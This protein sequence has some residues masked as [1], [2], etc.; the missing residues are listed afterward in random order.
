[1]TAFAESLLLLDTW[2]AVFMCA[3]IGVW[4]GNLT[5]RPWLALVV[6]MLVGTPC[7]G[8]IVGGLVV[9]FDRALL[10][11]QFIVIG[12]AWLAGNVLHGWSERLVRTTG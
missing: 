5:R 11:G 4:T 9:T 10:G 8:A 1:M 6:A 3:C 12:G 2:A 7:L